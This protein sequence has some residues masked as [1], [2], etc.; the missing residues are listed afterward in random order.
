MLGY[1]RT[2]E[3]KIKD[4]DVSHENSMDDLYSNYVNVSLDRARLQN[5]NAEL[6][7]KLAHLEAH[8]V[9]AAGGAVML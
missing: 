9:L 8:R 2:L 1:I 5:D 6:R 7:R 3:Q 4:T